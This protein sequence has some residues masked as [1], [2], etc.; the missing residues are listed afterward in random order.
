MS[1]ANRLSAGRLTISQLE[2]VLGKAI[3]D[4]ALASR[5]QSAPEATLK[6]MGYT[7]HPE[8]IQ[9]FKS[10]SGGNF[11]AAAAELNSKDPQHYSCEA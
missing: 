9:F 4:P 1:A 5:L 11:S 6:S 7:P 10:L 2:T 3:Q 8:E